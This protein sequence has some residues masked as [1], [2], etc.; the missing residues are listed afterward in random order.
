[1]F[2]VV[3]GV[4]LFCFFYCLL[5][6]FVVFC[7]F[8]YF[9]FSSRRRHTRCLSDW[10]SDVCSSDLQRPVADARRGRTLHADHGREGE[11]RPLVR[12]AAGFDEDVHSARSTWFSASHTLSDVSGMSMFR[13]PACASASMTAFTNAAGEPTVAD[14]PTPLAPIGW[15]GDGVTVSPSSKPGVSHDVGSR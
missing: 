13:T 14:S 3:L 6:G 1:M 8:C 10:S 2:F 5:V 7:V 11:R 4:A 9:F 12:Q 15:C